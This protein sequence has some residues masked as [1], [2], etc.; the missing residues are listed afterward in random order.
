VLLEVATTRPG[1]DVDEP[2]ETLGESL[3]LPPAAEAER[4]T[5][6]RTLPPI[7]IPA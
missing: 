2:R 5:L 7:T 3:R 4:G 1:F 6:E